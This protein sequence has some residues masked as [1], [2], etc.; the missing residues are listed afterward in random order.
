MDSYKTILIVFRSPDQA[1]RLC[2]LADGLAGPWQSHV[3]GFPRQ[4]R[5][6]L[7]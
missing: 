7:R 1:E 2:L 4:A 5:A 6:F 3:L